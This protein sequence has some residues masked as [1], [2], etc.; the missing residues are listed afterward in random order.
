MLSKS[1]ILKLKKNLL[2][3]NF[4]TI[5][6][7]CYLLS[8]QTPLPLPLPRSLPLVISTSLPR[9][10]L[11]VLPHSLCA[12]PPPAPAPPPPPH[13]SRLCL[14]YSSPLSPPPPVCFGLPR[15]QLWLHQPQR[16]TGR[17]NSRRPCPELKG[18]W[19][20]TIVWTLAFRASR[21][22]GS[23][24]KESAPHHKP[25]LPLFRL[26]GVIKLNK[27][28]RSIFYTIENSRREEAEGWSR[29]RS[30]ARRGARIRRPRGKGRRGSPGSITSAIHPLIVR[31][32]RASRALGA[33]AQGGVHGSAGALGTGAA[34]EG[35]APP[36]AFARL[37]PEPGAPTQLYNPSL[38][39]SFYWVF[40]D[41]GR[42][43]GTNLI[44]NS[45]ITKSEEKNRW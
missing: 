31:P 26:Q 32:A 34:E 24:P 17:G 6:N 5:D 38:F 28:L 18:M 3:G 27:I 33:G 7:L 13:L 11:H 23:F 9:P 43:R 36:A 2:I 44:W 12:P 22:G 15:A 45:Y 39:C 40:L 1:W 30:F 35:A 37:S 41:Q 21:G 29:G 25:R 42:K 4:F 10:S 8:S 16:G 20:K 14:P 19:R